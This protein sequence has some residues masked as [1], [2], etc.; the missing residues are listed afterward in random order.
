MMVNNRIIVTLVY[1]KTNHSILPSVITWNNGSIYI[2]LL[3]TWL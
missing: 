2:T 1:S 3:F